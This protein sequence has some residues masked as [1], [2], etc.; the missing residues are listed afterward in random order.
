MDAN[1]IAWLENTP[2]GKRSDALRN[3]MRETL[4]AIFPDNRQDT[5]SP[6]LEAIRSVI[7]DELQKALK[8]TQFTGVTSILKSEKHDM[9]SK[10]GDKLNRM[11]GIYQSSE[12]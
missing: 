4:K 3:M 11:L 1:L 12:W 9:E 8:D 7:A 5:A 6:Y 2:K 10:Y